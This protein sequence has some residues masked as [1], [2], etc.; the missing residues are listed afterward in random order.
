MTAL[1]GTGRMLGLTVRRERIHSPAWFGITGLVLA[2]VAAGIVATYPT[3]GARADLAASV[4]K[5]VGELFLIGRIG[6]ADVGSLALWRTQ[7][8]AAILTGIAAVLAVIRN[9]RAPEEDGRVE[10]LGG[11]RIGRSAPL[12]SALA[13][14]ALGSV[15]AGIIAAIGFLA[16]GADSGGTLLVGVQILLLG[17]VSASAAALAGQVVRTSHGATGIAMAV[18]AAFYLLRGAGDV[19]GGAGMWLSPFGWIAAVRPFAGTE[20]GMLL[21]PLALAVVLMGLALQIAAG[22]DLGAGAL[23]DRAGRA[24]AS[25]LLRGGVSLAL[26]TARGS[27]IGWTVGALLTG[28][29]IGG[30]ASTVDQQVQL[31][32]A[33]VTNGRG[34]TPVAAYLS[35]MF[36]AVFGIL[37]VL[38]MRSDVTSGR[39]D[40]VLSRAVGRG[41]WLAAY[42]V[43]GALGSLLVTTT[44]GLGVGLATPRMLGGYLLAGVLRAAAAWV[45]VAATALLVVTLPRAGTILAFALL[46]VYLVLELLVEFHAIPTMSLIASPFALATQLPDGPANLPTCM[47]LLVLSAL[48]LLAARHAVRR[49]D[50]L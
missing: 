35:A 31:H 17:L 5:S 29:L 9:T 28:L 42:I 18:V 19:I 24:T 22:R 43:T 37:A 16:I 10:L 2:A 1:T 8:I 39:A 27:M 32:V 49:S 14:T 33:G 11:A 20:P 36:A 41:R 4:G 38:R 26:R 44:F 45:F 40:A 47:L 21:P 15:L 48:L 30:V 7:G 25:V 46:V 12:A 23:P 3:P 6:G 13:V 34:L 50:V